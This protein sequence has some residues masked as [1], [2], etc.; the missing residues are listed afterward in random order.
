M[1]LRWVLLMTGLTT[2]ASLCPPGTDLFEGEKCIS[3]REYCLSLGKIINLSGSEDVCLPC[4]GRSTPNIDAT[5]CIEDAQLDLD[6]EV[7]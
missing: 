4:Q 7:S 2:V 6:Q 5:R 3:V 1:I